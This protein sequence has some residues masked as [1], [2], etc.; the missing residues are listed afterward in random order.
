VHI[1]DFFLPLPLLTH[2]NRPIT[3]Q[4]FISPDLPQTSVVRTTVALSAKIPYPRRSNASINDIQKKALRIFA[5]D[6]RP[7]PT[8][9][10]CAAWFKDKFGRT[11]DRATVSRILSSQY[12]HL[13]YGEAGTKSRKSTAHWPLL[14]EALF[15]WQ[16]RHTEKGFPMTGP[17][18]RLKAAEYWKKLPQYKDQ[19]MPAFSDGW[20]TGF[21]RRYSIKW[22]TFHGQAASVPKSIH[23][24]MEAIQVICDS[25]KP[26]DIYNMDETGLYWRRMPNGGLSSK[27]RPGQ[28]NGKTRITI[29]VASNATGSDKLPLWI[30]GTSKTPHALRG[31]DMTLFGCIWRYNKKA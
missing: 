16:R 8:Q 22:H 18:I 12:N 3:M 13:D 19:K 24:E 11:I 5:S 23:Y 15:E 14:D 25:Y 20:L 9:K 10:A 6:T 29:V 1:S 27:G 17:L 7:K 2:H 26:D 21:K 30:I 28:K 4:H 31:I